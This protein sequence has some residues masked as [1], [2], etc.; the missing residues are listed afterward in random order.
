MLVFMVCGV[1]QNIYVFSR[2]RN[3]DLDDRIFYCLRS[4]M[5]AVQTENI[6]ASLVFVEWP[7]SG[8]VGFYHHEPSWSCS[9]CPVAISWLSA[10]PMHVMEHLTS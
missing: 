2:Y 6:R 9:F 8:V 4:S 10:Q 7:S 5:V 1:R 3:P